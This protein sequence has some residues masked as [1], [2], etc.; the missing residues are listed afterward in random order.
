MEEDMRP[1][2]GSRLQHDACPALR[3]GT[4][5]AGF[6]AALAAFVPAGPA[7]AATINAST[8]GMCGTPNCASDTIIGALGSHGSYAFPWTIQ[9]ASD[10]DQ[11]VRLETAKVLGNSGL[12]LEM[13][14]VSPSGVVYRDDD[15]GA[16]NL[17]LVKITPTE[18]G[19]YTVQVSTANGGA[20]AVNF[21]LRYGRYASPTNPN[22]ATPTPPVLSAISGH[23]R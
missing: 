9:V 5:A 21:K 22:C 17:S 13:V 14:V 18:Q 10:P 16:G 4:L 23:A 12:N 2:L 6:V 15:G 1:V 3:P 20:A 19:F 11:C 8:L 7:G